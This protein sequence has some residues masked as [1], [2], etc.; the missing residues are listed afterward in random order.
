MVVAA[1]SG[2]M[3]WHLHRLLKEDTEKDTKLSKVPQIMR[4][5]INQSF[6]SLSLIS[7][8]SV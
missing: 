4:L 3:I 6:F 7:E 1:G 2:C 5:K 8:H